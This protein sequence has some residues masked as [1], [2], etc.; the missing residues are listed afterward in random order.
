MRVYRLC[1]SGEKQVP[2]VDKDGYFVLGSPQAGGEKH[3]AKN[4]I[5]TGDEDKMI[6]LL[7]LGYSIRIKTLKSTSLIRLNLFVDGVRIS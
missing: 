6:A 5:R 3:H 1:K 2:A 7:H 4:K